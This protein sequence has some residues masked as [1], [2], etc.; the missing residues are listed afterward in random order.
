LAGVA[1][2]RSALAAALAVAAAVSSASGLPDQACFGFAEVEKKVRARP[3]TCPSSARADVGSKV[4]GAGL[5][6]GLPRARS[7]GPAQTAGPS[8]P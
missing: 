5:Y 2:A 1:F 7:G 8:V 3:E 6:T 4:P